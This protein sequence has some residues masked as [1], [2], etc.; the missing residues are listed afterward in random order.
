MGQTHASFCMAHKL[1]MVFYFQMFEGKKI[2]WRRILQDIEGVHEIQ[3]SE[4]IIKF[5]GGTATLIHFDIV[6][7]WLHPTAKLN[8]KSCNRHHMAGKTENVYY[9]ALYRKR[10]P[11]PHSLALGMGSH[12]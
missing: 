7:D 10:E 1:R 11:N 12:V 6:Y 4:S 9:L 2:K 3:I 8:L 5:L